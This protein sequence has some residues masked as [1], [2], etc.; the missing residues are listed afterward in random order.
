MGCLLIANEVILI[1]SYHVIDAINDVTDAINLDVGRL[2]A[3][4]RRLDAIKL[5]LNDE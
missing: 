2:D 3:N 1:F 4:A 5:L